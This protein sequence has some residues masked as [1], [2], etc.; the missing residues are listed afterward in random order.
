MVRTPHVTS[1]LMKLTQFHKGDYIFNTLPL[2][3]SSVFLPDALY[4]FILTKHPFF[5]PIVIKSSPIGWKML[6]NL[7]TRLMLTAKMLEENYPQRSDSVITQT[8][9]AFT[10]LRRDVGD[11]MQFTS[12]VA[13]LGHISRPILQP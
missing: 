8:P 13:R 3:H 2:K 5:Q 12:R 7:A 6:P 4:A 11:A 9:Q 1:D 10:L